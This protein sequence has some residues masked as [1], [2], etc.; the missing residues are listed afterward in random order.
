MSNL[1]KIR[2]KI[3]ALLKKTEANGA[4]EAEAATA[5]GVASK[6]M[7]EYGVTLNDIHENNA[8]ARDF[9]K[10]RFNEGS[11]NLSVIDKF[12]AVAISVYTDTKAW[13]SK[14]F[15]GFKAGVKKAKV[16]Y[17]SNLM[18]YGYSVDVE[19]AYYIYKICESAVDTEWKKFSVSLPKGAR[20]AARITFQLGMAL[21]LR[22]RLVSMKQTNVEETN[23]KSLV[24]LKSQMVKAAFEEEINPKFKKTNNQ[25]V[26]YLKNQVFNA[27]KEAGDRVQFNRVVQ[28]GPTGGV[29]LI[30]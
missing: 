9:I 26:K 13:N 3:A 7:A 16:K 27:G 24:V 12:V 10:R 1:D 5:M 11:K 18:F 25:G 8:T 6:L 14:E 29:K 19:L 4:S 15:D 20:G 23:G 2:G 22:D 17:E 30:A 21:R 28:D